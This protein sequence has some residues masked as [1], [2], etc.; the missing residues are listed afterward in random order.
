MSRDFGRRLLSIGAG[1][2]WEQ[3][4][5]T[6]QTGRSSWLHHALRWV[7]NMRVP[8]SVCHYRLHV[9]AEPTVFA[10]CFALFFLCLC[11][12]TEKWSREEKTAWLEYIQ[13]FQRPDNGLFSDPNAKARITDAAHDQSHLDNQLTGFCLSALRIFGVESRYPILYVERWFDPNYMRH[14][15]DQLNWRQCSNSGNKAM[16]IA[17]MLTAELERGNARAR[18]GL[19]S[20]F[21]WHNENAEK[22]TSYWGEK[23]EC[24]YFQGMKGFVHQFLIYNYMECKVPN[25]HAATDRTLLLQQP[26]GLFSPMLDG[27]S[28]DDLDAIHIL[29]CSYHFEPY[30][31]NEIKAA[32]RRCLGP[33]LGNQNPDGGFCWAQRR[34]LSFKDW[35]SLT[36]HNIRTGDPLLTYLALRTA[37]SGQIHLKK[38]IKTGWSSGARNW[39]DSSLWD[40]WFRVL[41][42]AEID[43]VLN[44]ETALQRWNRI[45][46][47]NF[48]WFAIPQT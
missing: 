47:P 7:D 35:I 3:N 22:V 37:L 9:G 28:C 25:L 36:L 26:D 17:I 1:A 10:S 27:G 21:Q 18:D 29:S 43:T 4:S 39:S 48:S 16:F 12:E 8:G 5:S 19:K 32:L 41:A 24:R 6:L 42:I 31:R 11:R 33:L 30:R 44:P 20:W 15:L 23:V 13:S 34:K 45:N 14:W 2:D 40:T 46:T 38:M